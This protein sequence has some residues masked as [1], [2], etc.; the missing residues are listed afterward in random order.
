MHLSRIGLFITINSCLLKSR[1]WFF[2]FIFKSSTS[3]ESFSATL[4]KFLCSVTANTYFN[5]F[6]VVILENK[7]KKP[8]VETIKVGG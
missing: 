8:L 7:N 6:M 4:V 3:N 5:W 1:Y 2:E